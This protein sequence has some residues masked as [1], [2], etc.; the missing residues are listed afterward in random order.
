VKRRA[1][2]TYYPR[3]GPRAARP[4]QNPHAVEKR[5]CLHALALGL[6]ARCDR[7]DVDCFEVIDR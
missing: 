7:H 1:M 5:E 6:K 3:G 4:C 2:G